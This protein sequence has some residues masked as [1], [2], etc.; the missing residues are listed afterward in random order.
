[1]IHDHANFAIRII[2]ALNESMHNFV[3]HVD[4]KSESTYT[5]MT[6]FAQDKPN[7]FVLTDRVSGNWGGF[8]LVNMTL[9]GM[10]FA[11]QNQLNFDFLVDISG[12]S[13][14]IK[15]NAVIRSTLAVDPNAIYMDIRQDP[16]VPAPELWHHYVE[17]DDAAHRITRLQ[18]P[19]G[20]YMFMGSQW[21]ILPRHVVEWFLTDLLPVGFVDYA[22]HI[23]VADEHYFTTMIKNS[24]YC[25]D[26]VNKNYNYLVFGEWEQQLRSSMLERDLRKCNQP[27]PEHCG[28]SPT[29]LTR[30]FERSVKSS[31]ALFARKFDP[32]NSTSMAF[33]DVVDQIRAIPPIDFNA[34]EDPYYTFMIRQRLVNAS[35]DALKESLCL[36]LGSV[37]SGNKMTAGVCDPYDLTQWFNTGQC[38]EVG[39][40]TRETKKA[41]EQMCGGKVA[42]EPDQ[43]CFFKT[44]ARQIKNATDSTGHTSIPFCLDIAG[45]NPRPGGTMIG[46][47]CTGGWNQHFRCG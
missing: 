7:V 45:E 28:R 17:C 29:T 27:D 26:H 43:F 31:R 22:Q 19:R 10:K 12:Q 16:N 3:V 20:I 18:A 23:M 42:D 34:E 6:I 33:V 2:E 24:P 15:S 35:E 38:I 9:I 8:S 30:Q 25:A 46:Y 44:A 41:G 11:I 4:K 1:M 39:G 47:D 40:E 13:Y 36:Q 21:F 37:S 32:A 14:P 5:A